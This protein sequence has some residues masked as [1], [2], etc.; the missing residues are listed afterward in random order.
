MDPKI[1]YIALGSGDQTP[2]TRPFSPDSPKFYFTLGQTVYALRFLEER[3]EGQVGCY[4]MF[5][6]GE[7]QHAPYTLGHFDIL[8]CAPGTMTAT[9]LLTFD[10]EIESHD[11]LLEA[12]K[13]A[14][15]PALRRA[16]KDEPGRL[17]LV[18]FQNVN[19]V[20][21]AER[22]ATTF[23]IYPDDDVPGMIDIT[24]VPA[25][26]KSNIT[27]L[28]AVSLDLAI[29]KDNKLLWHLPEDLKLF[30]ANTLGRAVLMGRK[31]AESVGRA[32]PNRRN[33][34]LTS[35]EAPYPGQEV[36]RSLAEALELV[37]DDELCVIGGQRV[38]A[39]AMPHAKRLKITRVHES[40]PEADAHFPDQSLDIHQWRMVDHKQFPAVGEQPSF[41]Y[42]EY[43]RHE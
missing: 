12:I 17:A 33:I 42:T 43:V 9:E 26:L 38:Y 4:A 16:Y 24:D 18:N 29:G 25:P 37:G 19:S 14:I 40:Y 3:P 6:Q 28:M 10:I 15:L 5:K 7:E 8:K 41:E 11:E 35:G 2:L 34:V 13:D 22:D 36:V 30:K 1:T 20:E 31:T 27:I 23:F 21:V 32:L 39:E